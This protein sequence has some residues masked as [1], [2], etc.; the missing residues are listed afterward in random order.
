MIRAPTARSATVIM[1]AATGVMVSCC[2]RQQLVEAAADHHAGR[3]NHD[4][5]G[6][7]CSRRPDHPSS[8][9]KFYLFGLPVPRSHRFV[10]L[11]VGRNARLLA[12]RAFFLSI[13]LRETIRAGSD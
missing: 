13:T 1:I 11:L 2:F 9:L 3:S 7:P 10:E 4:H 5:R 12:S 8:S 6:A